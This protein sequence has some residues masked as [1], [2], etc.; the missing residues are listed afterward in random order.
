MPEMLHGWMLSSL[1]SKSDHVEKL[2]AY[3]ARIGKVSGL[4][5]RF[6]GLRNSFIKLA[7]R[8]PMLSHS[9]TNRLVNYSRL[10]NVSESYASCRNGPLDCVQ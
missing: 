8:E 1:S 9:L 10:F 2:Y 7:E 5:L 3:N 4:E 6:H